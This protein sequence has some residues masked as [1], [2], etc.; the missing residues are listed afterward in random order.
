MRKSKVK[1]V[2]TSCVLIL[3]LSLITFLSLRK[4]PETI[5]VSN[6][7]ETS[8][9][10]IS[11]NFLIKNYSINKDEIEVK[12]LGFIPLKSVRVSKIN[13]LELYPGGNTVGIKLSTKGVLVVGYS[14][15]NCE[16]GQVESPAKDL[17]VQLGDV[18][19]KKL[20]EKKLKIQGS[21]KKK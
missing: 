13:D 12:F 19:V 1:I 4:I 20:M 14:D 2:Y 21:F 8:N 6:S 10:D 3:L 11:S 5:Y 18:I 15:V 17:V 16:K 7:I 9:M